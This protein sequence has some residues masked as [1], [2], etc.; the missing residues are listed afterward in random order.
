[1]TPN[2]F[3]VGAAWVP[4]FVVSTFML[5][6]WHLFRPQ[7]EGA[8][9]GV[10]RGPLDGHGRRAR[11]AASRDTL[12]PPAMQ[13]RA[14]RGAEASNDIDVAPIP[15]ARVPSIELPVEGGADEELELPRLV[16]EEDYS[17]PPPGFPR[18]SGQA[19]YDRH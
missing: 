13:Q 4:F 19:R 7:R 14:R 10:M 6:R 15:R 8:L 5:R 16:F 17:E 18:W 9:D 11:D 12:R 3:M 1:M 2:W